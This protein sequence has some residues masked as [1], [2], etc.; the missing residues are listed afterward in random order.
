MARRPPRHVRRLPRDPA[1]THADVLG[2][3]TVGIPSAYA[4]ATLNTSKASAAGLTGSY[5]LFTNQV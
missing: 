1:L 3:D 2:E 4:S 5:K